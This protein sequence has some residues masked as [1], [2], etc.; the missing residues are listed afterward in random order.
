MT[1]GLVADRVVLWAHNSH[2][3]DARSTHLGPYDDVGAST[4]R[5]GNLQRELNI[6]QLIKEQFSEA[7]AITVGQLTYYGVPKLLFSTVVVLLWLYDY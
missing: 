6:G 2:L 5:L 4:T 7:E 3:G 1:R